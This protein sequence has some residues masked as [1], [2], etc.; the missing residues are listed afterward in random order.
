MPHVTGHSGDGSAEYADHEVQVIY[1]QGTTEDVPN[2]EDAGF[3]E[4]I[5]YEPVSER[6]LD[7][8]ELAE[9]VGFRGHFN[10]RHGLR[11][12]GTQVNRPNEFFAEV[13]LGI[14]LSLQE[15]AEQS[16]QNNGGERILTTPESSLD[17]DNYAEPGV[18][19]SWS[20]SSNAQFYDD[21]LVDTAAALGG[22]SAAQPQHEREMFFPDKLGSGPYVDRTDDITVH[23]EMN[24]GNIQGTQAI[25]E[26]SYI[27]YWNV[28]EMPEGRASFARP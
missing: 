8:D 22:G 26:G 10:L 3:D 21:Q 28:Q 17:K 19:D 6:G 5:E 2:G 18:L 9:L 25:I 7:S 16:N 11:D 20:G 15:F 27:M 12:D 23:A 4:V 24:A 14:N 1:F 13:G